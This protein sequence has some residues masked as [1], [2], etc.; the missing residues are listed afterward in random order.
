MKTSA[1][2]NYVLTPRQF[3]K[4]VWAHRSKPLWIAEYHRHGNHDIYFQ[5]YV[6]TV[7]IPE[8]LKPW[9]VYSRR[10]GDDIHG[11]P[12]LEAAAKAGD[13]SC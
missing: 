5:V 11:F 13:E 3:G 6:A 12:T 7:P 9:D 4:A 10:L 8:G 1:L 2:A